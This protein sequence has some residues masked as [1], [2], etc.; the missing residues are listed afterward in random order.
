[1]AD[2]HRR[3]KS[4]SS[5]RQRFLFATR[6]TYIR[7]PIPEGPGR[8]DLRIVLR[9]GNLSDLLSLRCLITH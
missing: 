4:V 6:S 1:M 7:L 3:V 8:R 9:E 5:V 2:P